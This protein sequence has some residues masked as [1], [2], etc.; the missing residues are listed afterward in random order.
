MST[1]G[2]ALHHFSSDMTTFTLKRAET[3]SRPAA[4]CTFKPFT[5]QSGTKLVEVTME[6]L[7]NMGWGDTMGHGE[8]IYNVK[9]AREF[10]TSLLKR[11]FI[12]A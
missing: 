10:Y 8:G 3:Q 9:H 11:G 6:H 2:E 12:A 5:T 7:T 1:A 4:R